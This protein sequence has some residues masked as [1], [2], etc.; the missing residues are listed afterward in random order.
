MKS[1]D[2]SDNSNDTKLVTVL[3]NQMESEDTK[4]NKKKLCDAYIGKKRYD[5]YE[6]SLRESLTIDRMFKMQG[7]TDSEII[8]AMLRVSIPDC[9]ED[10]LL[11]LTQSQST[12]LLNLIK[13]ASAQNKLM[14]NKT[15][16]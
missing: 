15:F 14:E 8:L 12:E 7:V 2:N 11:D 16:H 3:Q 9:S 10:E 5:V 1:M 6:L 4:A 13:V